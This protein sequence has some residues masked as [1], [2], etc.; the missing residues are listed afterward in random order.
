[1]TQEQSDIEPQETT[2]PT[3]GERLKQAR[4]AAGLSKQALADKLF[5]KVAI[6]EQLESD[7]FESNT[8][9][10]FVKGYIKLY[11]K[12]VGVAAEPLLEMFEK[13]QGEQKQVPQKLQSFSR[14]V[15]N[16]ATDNRWMMVTYL[17]LTIVIALLVIWWYQQPNTTE[18]E[19]DEGV[20]GRVEQS[21]EPSSTEESLPLASSLDAEVFAANDADDTAVADTNAKTTDTLAGAGVTSLDQAD[22]PSAADTEG[23]PA[24][25]IANSAFDDVTQA[26]EANA[27]DLE[28]VSG[29]DLETVELVFTF[30]DDCWVNIEDATGTAIAYG[31]KVRGRVMPVS[32]VPPFE[33]TLGAPQNVSITYDG[34]PVDMSMYP[35]GRSARFNLP[36]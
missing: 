29:S 17:I 26:F 8:S 10:T 23:Q 15:S 11:A 27:P 16:E 13:Q 1:M 30:A 20:L 24:E 6:I 34:E 3:L 21:S 31:T 5:L 14:R 18:M 9:A 28:L 22:T 33:I 25:D 32:G 7:N 35:A 19:T 4:D 2:E 36:K 12:N